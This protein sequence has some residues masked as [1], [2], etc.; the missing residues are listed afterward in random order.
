VRQLKDEAFYVP[1]LSGEI[2]WEMRSG[3]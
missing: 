1:E 2:R 3:S